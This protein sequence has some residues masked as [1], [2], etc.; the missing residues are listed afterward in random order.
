MSKQVTLLIIE[1]DSTIGELI[2]L[3]VQNTLTTTRRLAQCVTDYHL[4]QR[5]VPMTEPQAYRTPR[6]V[7]VF[8]IVVLIIILLHSIL[9]FTGIGGQHGPGRHLR[10]ATP[11]IPVQQ[12]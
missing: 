7:K 9:T 2:K 1:D 5:G 8:G 11:T 10:I 4:H 12:P 3:F 6:W